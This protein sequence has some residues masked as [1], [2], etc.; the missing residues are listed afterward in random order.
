MGKVAY[1][2]HVSETMTK[3]SVGAPSQ[4]NQGSRRKK[5]AWRKNVDIG[6]VEVGLEE[7]RAEERVTWY[8]LSLLGTAVWSP[9]YFSVNC[10]LYRTTLQQQQNN[11]IFQIE[12]KGD[13]RSKP[14][15][16]SYAYHF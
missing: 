13:E 15:P 16:W 3:I 7:L 6:E 4:H 11:E 5:R 12:V 1:R 14:L 8:V 10:Y 2:P 9:I